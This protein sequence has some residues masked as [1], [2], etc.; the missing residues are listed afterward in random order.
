M[1]PSDCVS[2]IFLG[3]TPDPFLREKTSYHRA[4]TDGFSQSMSR[5]TTGHKDNGAPA[6][7][8]MHRWLV[9]SEPG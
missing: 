9:A 5:S 2:W 4:G 6:F 8:P 7:E 3:E 1:S